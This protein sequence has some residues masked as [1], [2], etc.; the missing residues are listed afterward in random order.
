MSEYKVGHKLL[1][2][3]TPLQNTLEELFYLLNFLCPAKFDVMEVFLNNFCDISK[4]DQIGRLHDMLGV[5]MLRRL[6]ADVLKGFASKAEFLVRTE[7]SKEQKFYYKA[8]LTKNFDALR[9]KAGPASTSLINIMM[10]LRKVCNHPY[11]FAKAADDAPKLPNGYYEGAALVKSCGK[12][13]ILGQMLT[14]LKKQ[15]HRV[16][17]FS[18]MTRLLDLLE[19]AMD[20]WQ[21]RYER[22]DGSV[23]GSVRQEAID[24][25]NAPNAEQFVFLLST[26]A[27]GLG[28]NL[29]TADTVVIYDS[30]WNPHNDIQA[31]SRAHR[32]GQKNQV[33]I[34]RFV[35]R[36]SV[37]ERIQ[38][39]AKK[40]MMLTHLV[41]RPGMGSN[42]L[43][44]MSKNEMDDILKFG[45][46][47][48]F[49]DEDKE[50]NIEY[51]EATI[52]KLLDRSQVGIKKLDDEE[53]G[54][55]NDYL[56]SFKVATYKTKDEEEV[57][58]DREVIAQEETT[59][60]TATFWENLLRCHYEDEVEVEQAS[61]GKGKR[62]RKQVQYLNLG[63]EDSKDDADADIGDNGSDSED[64]TEKD[65][66]PKKLKRIQEKPLPPLLSRVNGNLEVYGFSIRARRA[67]MNMIMRWGL[68]P[69]NMKYEDRPYVRELRAKSDKEFN[70]Y[71]A[72]FTRHLCE[73]EIGNSPTYADGIPKEGMQRQMVLFRIGIMSLIKKK[74][75]EFEAINGD[76]SEASRKPKIIE[77]L[78]DQEEK[79][80]EII[81]QPDK[82][83]ETPED[84][85]NKSASKSP[86]KEEKQS[87]KPEESDDKT[88]S[89]TPKATPDNL[90]TSDSKM[91]DEDPISDGDNESN[92]VTN[93]PDMKYDHR[94]NPNKKLKKRFMFN[95]ADSGFTELHTLWNTEEVAAVKSGRLKEIWHRMHDYWLLAGIAKHG[96]SR[97]ADI[98]QD[99]QFSLVQQPFLAME[100]KRDNLLD[101][102]KG[103][104]QRRFKLLETALIIE[105]QLRRAELE[106]CQVSQAH[107]ALALAK[108]FN[109]LESLAEA[110]SSLTKDSSNQMGNV[111]LNR[112]LTRLDELLTD[113][114]QDL[115]RLPIAIS[116][117]QTV[118]E[119][120]GM[121]ER[122]IVAHL[123][124]ASAN[125]DEGKDDESA[126][127]AQQRE[128]FKEIAK[129]KSVA[130]A[131]RFCDNVGPFSVGKAISFS[132]KVNDDD[133]IEIKD[134][135]SQDEEKV[136]N[137]E[138]EVLMKT[139]DVEKTDEKEDQ[140]SEEN[141]I[142]EIKE[143]LADKTTEQK[144]AETTEAEK[145]D[146]KPAESE[147]V[148]DEVEKSEIKEEPATDKTPVE[149][150]EE[151]VE[152]METD[153]TDNKEK[154]PDK[155]D[156]E[157]K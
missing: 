117:L 139:D 97:W 114:K 16:L 69:D 1:L 50:K 115:A 27:G 45:T 121:N 48:L 103:F 38:Q 28:I 104:L 12:L 111:V 31:F 51:D 35:T 88:N 52:D 5:H 66:K 43:T 133:V 91:T 72:L 79:I 144:E 141:K 46:E 78:E 39:T 100:K 18:Q 47:E 92:D 34:Y 101:M 118:Q 64:E 98:Q 147:T 154:T 152:T 138:K 9:T 140:K 63:V 59:E 23:T 150:K 110:H 60:N 58:V 130:T 129:N 151:I 83:S 65:L 25:F 155:N 24:R 74:V 76:W 132:V 56:S 95:I 136:E 128:Q 33:M 137:S 148:N 149:M 124:T 109:E 125:L 135:D 113:M 107:E 102:Q 11:L 146:D 22:I 67:F 108:H 105:E 53:N 94:L 17:I 30:D 89:D 36:N 19:D 120:L 71:L 3:G 32:I 85:Q 93:D 10:D 134:D 6:K 156:D 122:Y 127:V 54:L 80:V 73:P 13:T 112:C 42:K 116:Q 62:I 68:P 14:K 7:M 86:E 15:G 131:L 81:E 99:M 26:K 157:M 82:N 119:R 44:G 84:A 40:K 123:L 37:E 8:V 143:E 90:N 145:S 77:E 153:E 106:R 21:Y 70:A 142:E 4:E 29:A 2:T 75:E 126:E 96:Y 41:V 57:E 87:D 61:M 20:F 49:K 55:L